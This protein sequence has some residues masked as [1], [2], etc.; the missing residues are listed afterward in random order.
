MKIYFFWPFKDKIPTS[1]T[2]ES[3]EFYNGLKN[4]ENVTL[5]NSFQEADYIFFMMDLYNCYNLKHYNNV[6]DVNDINN[7][8]NHTEHQKD[9]IIDYNDWTNTSNNI[10]D[11]KLNLVAKY[12]KRSMVDKKLF[13]LIDYS[14]EI[15]PI[16]YGIRSDFINYDK[17]YDFKYYNYDICCLFNRNDHG[18]IRALLYDIVIKYKG[19]KFVGRVNAPNCYGSVNKKYFNILKTSKIIITANPPN[20]EGDFRLWEALLMGNLVLCDRMII[21]HIIK[22]PL[23][24]KKH[25]VFYDK[26]SD[27]LD[28]INYYIKN[29]AE[30]NQIGKEGREY[31]LKHHKFSNRVKEVVNSLK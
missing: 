22:H 27:I 23:V 26:P 9:I 6:L 17:E 16:S 18:G 11:N 24:N 14:R 12:F 29:E 10:L 30:R 19:N 20:W 2:V 5:V 7:F 31:S 1:D 4:T 25:L 21:P 8:K 15:I 3:Y 28:L 13:K